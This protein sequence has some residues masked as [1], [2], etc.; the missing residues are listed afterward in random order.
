MK[1]QAQYSPL[2][3]FVSVWAACLPAKEKVL[4]LYWTERG[5]ALFLQTCCAVS[6]VVSITPL[7]IFNKS[8]LKLNFPYR[9]MI[10]SPLPHFCEHI[11]HACLIYFRFISKCSLSGFSACLSRLQLSRGLLSLS[12][13]SPPV[14]SKLLHHTSSA[15][16]LHLTPP[17]LRHSSR[18]F[19]IIRVPQLVCVCVW[20]RETPPDSL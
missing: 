9:S 5:R 14:T 19:K 3:I 4:F 1:N 2:Y 20:Q 16:R 11:P 6:V 7:S 10:E 17:V 8:F 15:I 13:S 18:P 12:Q